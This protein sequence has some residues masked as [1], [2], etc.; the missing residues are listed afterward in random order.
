MRCAGR[1]LR[2]VRSGAEAE[3]S[4]RPVLVDHRHDEPP[5]AA[6]S[7]V[8]GNSTNGQTETVIDI[9]H[10]VLLLPIG[11]KSAADEVQLAIADGQMRACAN[12]AEVITVAML[13]EI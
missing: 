13:R 12:A 9:A 5:K 1:Y 10:D 8:L 11:N 2:K 6:R 7:A 3:L 4:A